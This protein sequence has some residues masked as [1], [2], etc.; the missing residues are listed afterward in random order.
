MKLKDYKKTIIF[1][2][3]KKK[4]NMNIKT[5]SLTYQKLKMKQKL[6]RLSKES[7]KNFEDK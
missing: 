4:W 2:K 3:K 7:F 6:S 5:T 1:G